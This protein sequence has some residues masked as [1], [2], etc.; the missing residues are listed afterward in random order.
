MLSANAG[1]RAFRGIYSV[2]NRS[3]SL[4]K[5]DN[6]G[7]S[8][9]LKNGHTI[10]L[11][12]VFLRD[13]C[14][15]S[16][17]VDPFSKQKYFTTA[18]I[19]RDLAISGS[20]VVEKGEHEDIL[21]VTWLQNGRKHL[22]KY[23]E[24]FF[25]RYSTPEGCRKGKFFDSERVEWDNSAILKDIGD[26][27]VNYGDY[28]STEN[29]FCATVDNLNR[30]GISF[31][32]DIPDP[33][34]NPATQRISDENVLQWPVSQ[35]ASRFGYIKKTF[36]GSL[37]DVI[38]EKEK[39]KNIANTNKIL[40]LHMDLMYYES[41]PGVQFLHAIR[42]STLGGENIF[43]DSY[44][45]IKHVKK[46][47]AVAYEALKTVPVTYHYDNNS[48]Y[49]F[50]KRPMVVEDP[51]NADPQTGEPLLK[52][53]NYSPPFQG[54]FEHNVGVLDGVFDAFLR[55]MRIFEDFINDPK[56]QYKVKMREGSCVVFDNRRVLHSRTEFSDE[57]GGDRW[58]MGCYVDGDSF[59]SKLRTQKR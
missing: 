45:A 58:L 16:E 26:L 48:E 41:P 34:K 36:Y 35:I 31:V 54:P 47:D 7:I 28:L 49:Y 8:V 2:F 4:A 30:F 6:N 18:D 46:T 23:T 42:N 43:S 22:S 11:G 39:T 9:T 10:A 33:T 59:R 37:F 1:T 32:N 57:N 3:L 29:G 52:E 12:N 5:Y 38:N 13:A 27:Q 51:Y 25:A 55:G 44:L 50:Y 20:P 19:S 14:S 53:V 17:S 40:G 15:S 56:N 21:V 24:S